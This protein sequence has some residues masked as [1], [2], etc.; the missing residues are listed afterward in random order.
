MD[1]V[2]ST[3]GGVP[4]KVAFIRNSGDD[5]LIHQ[6]ERMKEEDNVMVA[7]EKFE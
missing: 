2:P 4:G 6:V 1:G 7:G 5:E 3:G